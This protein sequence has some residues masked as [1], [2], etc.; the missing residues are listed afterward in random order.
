MRTRLRL[1]ARRLK[2]VSLDQRHSID[3]AFY[4]APGWS[5]LYFSMQ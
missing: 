2:I 4:F 1:F 3:K 5:F